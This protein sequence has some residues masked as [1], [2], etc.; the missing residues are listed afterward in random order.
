MKIA[1]ISLSWKTKHTTINPVILVNE[2]ND[3][4]GDGTFLDTCILLMV[5]VVIVIQVFG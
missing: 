4:D 2:R 3:D 5:K 1:L